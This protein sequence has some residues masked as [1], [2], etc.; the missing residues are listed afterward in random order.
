MRS[1]AMLIIFL[2]LVSCQLFPKNSSGG[3]EEAQTFDT[4]EE[5]IIINEPPPG[6]VS[7]F[8]CV[9]KT[10]SENDASMF[11]QAQ[12]YFSGVLFSYLNIY[13][14]YEETQT[15]EPDAVASGSPDHSVTQELVDY[16][17]Q[18]SEWPQ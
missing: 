17:E 3:A 11:G 18:L 10:G 9:R 1:V 5:N 2:F 13:E 16:G 7:G 8:G 6:T 4:G 12:S 14:C 15:S